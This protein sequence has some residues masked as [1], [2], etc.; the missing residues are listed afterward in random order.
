MHMVV[1]VCWEVRNGG[2]KGGDRST[3]Q[4]S[5]LPLAGPVR[6]EKNS[7]LRIRQNPSVSIESQP[8]STC[9]QPAAPLLDLSFL[10]C[11]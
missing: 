10:F 11:K 3:P 7:G 4:H 8:R 5:P 9:V 1:H 6:P 2:A